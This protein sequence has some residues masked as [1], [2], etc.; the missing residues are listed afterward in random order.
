[1]LLNSFESSGNFLFKYRG[2]IP[3]VLFV[4]ALFFIFNTNYDCCSK[5]MILIF[6]VLSIAITLLGFLIR[7]YSIGSTTLGTSGRNT[8]KQVAE[9]LNS[10]G[11]YSLVRHPLYL[12]NYLIWLGIICYTLNLY[13]IFIFSL[14]YWIYYERIMFA[15]E[16]FLYRKFK[17]QYKKWAS[18]TPAFI[19][20]FKLFK[21]TTSP[22][23]YKSIFRREY[24][25][26]M[27]TIVSYCYV[28]ILQQ[29]V[30]KELASWP[31]KTISVFFIGGI[32]TLTLRILKKNTN[33]LKEQGRS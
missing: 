4:L 7:F 20:N 15:E 24:S 28:E 13:F 26:F 21:P 17:D 2:Q 22:F 8:Q 14:L 12:G 11:I 23:S 25:G 1:M 19:P 31:I 9:M 3:V 32:I 10:I 6:K 33:L 16:M 5:E 27:A 29:Y 30:K 18:Y